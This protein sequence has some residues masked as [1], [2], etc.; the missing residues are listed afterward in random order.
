MAIEIER[1]F[2]LVSDGWRAHVERQETIRQGYL[3]QR[4]IASV[5]V[6][7]AGDRA[8]MNIKQAIKG[9]RRLEYEFEIPL[10]DASEMLDALCERPLIEKTRYRVKYG[11]HEWEIDVFHGENAGLVV[12][13]IELE[14]EAVDFARPEWLGREVTE[15]ERYYNVSL[16]NYPYRQWTAAERHPDGQA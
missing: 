14:D 3:G 2:L 13:E 7:L 8:F 5:R 11:G 16:V 1:K 6:R 15:F 4:G 10:P 12:A 9:T